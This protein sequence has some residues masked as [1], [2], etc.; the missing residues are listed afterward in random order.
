MAARRDRAPAIPYG[1]G[2]FGSLL[3]LA[4]EQLSAIAD[5]ELLHLPYTGLRPANNDLLAGTL[6]LLIDTVTSASPD[7]KA[8]LTV[9]VAVMSLK[10]SAVFQRAD[11]DDMNPDFRGSRRSPGSAFWR[12]PARPSKRWTASTT[13]FRLHCAFLTSVSASMIWRSIR[14]TEHLS[15]RGTR[16]MEQ[17]DRGRP[18]EQEIN[19]S[20]RRAAEH[21]GSLLIV[22]RARRHAS[23]T[24]QPEQNASGPWTTRSRYSNRILLNHLVDARCD[25]ALSVL[26][27]AIAS[28]GEL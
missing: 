25:R 27:F 12:Q 16:Q 18:S 13:R 2:G 23:G 6:P 21:V 8:G 3:H 20:G 7:A 28:T 15:R 22:C 4:G 1:S 26:D 10:R 19:F 14:S 11:M 9:P 5:I 17:A 24:C